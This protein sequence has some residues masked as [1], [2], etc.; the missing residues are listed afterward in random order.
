MENKNPMIKLIIYG[1]V[2]RMM[3]S[4]LKDKVKSVDKNLLRGVFLR[5]IKD[6]DEDYREAM[7]NR[8]LLSRLHEKI[9]IGSSSQKSNSRKISSDSIFKDDSLGP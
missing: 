8:T 1:K 9:I 6:F 7:E 5:K 3:M 4:Y 2:K